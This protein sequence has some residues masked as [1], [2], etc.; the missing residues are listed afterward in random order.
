MDVLND[1]GSH[2]FRPLDV[3]NHLGLWMSLTTLGDELS[4][5]DTMNTS[6]L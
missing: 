6:G 4:A 5:L 3:V 1:L 2:Q